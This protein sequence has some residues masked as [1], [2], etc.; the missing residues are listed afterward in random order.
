M[1]SA[2]PG[3]FSKRVGS[4]APWFPVTP[5][6][7]R[8]APGIACGLNPSSLMTSHTCA[9]CASVASDFMTMSITTA[10]CILHDDAERD[11][12]SPA[13]HGGQSHKRF[14]SLLL[15]LYINHRH[16]PASSSGVAMGR[17]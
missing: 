9:T 16:L 8:V 5:I 4:T 11:E 6:A 10:F 12:L 17:S 7:V 3:R 13:S 1:A 14:Y 15:A 2:T